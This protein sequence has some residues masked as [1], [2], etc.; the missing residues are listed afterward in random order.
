MVK[1]G[2]RRT[3]NPAWGAVKDSTENEDGVKSAIVGTS[4]REGQLTAL[5]SE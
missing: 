5:M 1:V 2:R 3:L 4:I